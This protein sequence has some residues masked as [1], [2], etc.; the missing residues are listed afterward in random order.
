[1]EIR[2]LISVP[3]RVKQEVRGVLEVVD[4]TVNRFT[5]TDLSLIESLAATAAIAIENARLFDMEQRQRQAVEQALRETEGLYRI[6][7]IL[8]QTHDVQAAVSQ[9]LG[10]Y[11]HALDLTQGGIALFDPE[12]KA[13]QLYVLYRHGQVQPGR[14]SLEIT[15]RVYQHLIETRQPVVIAEAG[16]DPLLAD[17]QEL[18]I[19]HGI[20]SILFVPLLVQGQ[21][22]G[23]L[24]ADATEQPRH[25]SAREI[26]LGQAVADQ[27][28]GAVDR[29]RLD[30]SQRRLS[31]AMAQATETFIITDLAG[32][33]V[34]ANHYLETG[35]GDSVAEALGQ[36][37]NTLHSSRQNP[38]FYEE[39][40]SALRAGETWHGTFINKRKDGCLYHEEASIF[41]VK[42]ATGEVINYA[43]VKRDITERVQAEAE[44]EKIQAQLSQ[45]QKMESVGRLAGGVAH[46]FNN[47]LTIIFGYT[48]LALDQV[49]PDRPIFANLQE[50]RQAAERSA[51][52]TRQL[53]AFARKQPVAPRVLDLNETVEGMLKMLRRLIGENIDLVW[54]PGQSLGPV[55][56]DP[57]QIDQLL[58]NLCL[59]AR[60]AITGVGQI[61]IETGSAAFDEAY[62]AAHP[63]FTP[64]EYVSLEVRDDGSGMDQETLAKVFEP[65]FTTKEMGQGTGLGLATVYGIVEQ[66]QGFINVSSEPGQGT[67]FKIYLPRHTAKVLPLPKEEPVRPDPLGHETVLLVEDEPAILEIGK[68]MLE[69]FGYRVLAA[70][71]P[72]QAIRLAEQYP[73]EIHLLM[74]DVV[75]PGM[76]GRELT[77]RL[78]SLYPN[79]KH[80]FMSGY[81]ADIIASHGVFDESVNFIQKPFSM[82]DL[83]A[84]VRQILGQA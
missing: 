80:L 71:T 53:L 29:I 34:Y 67:T 78:L 63:S 77:Q 49:G 50:I 14:V 28:A 9:V 12:K 30:E 46:D 2:S 25:F 31:A 82:K 22:I 11:L 57:S 70:S 69:N 35:S 83:A 55:R 41:P 20:K 73:G 59:N 32:Q 4:T 43:T 75:M 76:N 54:R 5:P 7:S 51:D 62:C 38:T 84:R 66:N 33:I 15:S 64:G 18:T 39:L 45:A 52:L 44:R 24:G 40:W 79:L 68:L 3:L 56:L 37:P 17:S 60:D 26:N 10:E 74:T 23:A 6:S 1:V 16:S 19:A 42:N 8:V 27:V 81:S 13:V 58:A 61:T 21:V 72:G 48:E 65:F 47:M 36:N